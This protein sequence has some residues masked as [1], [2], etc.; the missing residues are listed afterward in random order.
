MTTI[1]SDGFTVAADGRVVA[2]DE[3]ISDKNVK[4]RQVKG[5]VIG[6]CGVM[7]YM[8]PAIEWLEDGANPSQIKELWLEGKDWCMIVFD[9]DCARCYHNDTPYPSE[10]PYPTAFGSGE[11]L[12][13]GALL[14]NASP[15]RAIQIASERDLKTG[16]KIT[17]MEIYGAAERAV[18]AE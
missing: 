14:A 2:G 8:S 12:A 15:E 16:G 17:V 3:F 9:P 7:A 4:L 6:F 13:I 5:R 18:A 11:L 1:A 10:V